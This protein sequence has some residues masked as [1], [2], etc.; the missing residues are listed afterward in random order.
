MFA[1]LLLGALPTPFLQD[2]TAGDPAGALVERPPLIAWQRNLTDAETLSRLT[3][4]PLLLCVNMDAEPASDRF[5]TQRYTSPE[6]AELAAHYVPLIISPTRHNPLDHDAL[7][8]RVVCPR[9]GVVIC[10]EH[11]EADTDTYDKY[12]DGQRV[13]PRHIGVSAAGVFLFDRYLD[14]DISRVDEAMRRHAGGGERPEWLHLVSS[15]DAAKRAQL[16]DAYLAADTETRKHILEIAWISHADSIDLLRLGL[17]EEDPALRTRAARALGSV[18]TGDA[19]LLALE[20]LNREHDAVARAALLESASRWV[21]R[22]AGVRTRLANLVALEARSSVVDGGRWRTDVATPQAAAP[23]TPREA[24]EALYERLEELG[25]T[26]DSSP[27]EAAPW[28]ELAE[29][30]FELGMRRLVAGQDPTFHLVDARHAAER[31]DRLGASPADVA[32][33]DAR[34]AWW[35]GEPDDAFEQ[36]GRALPAVLG[37][38]ASAEAGEVLAVFASSRAQR[39]YA[40]QESNG[41]PRE[42]LTDAHAAFSVLAFHPHGTADHAR[43]HA[44]LLGYVGAGALLGE[45][46]E[47]SL[48]RFPTDARLHESF[49]G[50]VERTRGLLALDSSYGELAGKL[51]EDALAW[52]A[53]YAAFMVAEENRRQNDEAAADASYSRSI[54]NF[55]RSAALNAQFADSV[56]HYVALAMAG[57]ARL[58]ANAGELERAAELIV[59]ALERRPSALEWPD[60]LEETPLMTLRLVERLSR[61][62]DRSELAERLGVALEA[63]RSSIE[64]S[65]SG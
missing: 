12:M 36:A 50:Y 25:A 1:P 43:A 47:V 26:I 45:I 57:R 62:A 18:T 52:F 42:W 48:A 55:E 31:A 53:G 32:S 2:S 58:A 13:A 61:E 9:F 63:T 56:D 37:R 60:G 14:Q 24:D 28:M 11:I 15:R 5:A 35:L 33:L 6:F 49:R 16:E 41:W 20:G 8:R 23:E 29:V 34:A 65:S 30:H 38:P 51:P 3:D 10:G 17:A 4:K 39:V 46:L 54:A 64:D 59:R 40:A 27:R 19:A 22:V 7:G 44:D 21:D